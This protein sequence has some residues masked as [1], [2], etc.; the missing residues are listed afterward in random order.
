MNEHTANR[1]VVELRRCLREVALDEWNELKGPKSTR[2][3]VTG[4]HRIVKYNQ[5][6]RIGQELGTA[7][8]GLQEHLAAGPA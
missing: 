6:L 1:G 4:T 2:S 5:L 3:L 7:G 8:E